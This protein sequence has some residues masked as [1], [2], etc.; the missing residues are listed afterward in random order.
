[1]KARVRLSL[2]RSRPAD[3]EDALAVAPPVPDRQ[4]ASQ[5]VR[6]EIRR[7]AVEHAPDGGYGDTETAP[8]SEDNPA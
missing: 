5:D 2:G 6:E 3:D 4:D 1:M 8:V 7:V